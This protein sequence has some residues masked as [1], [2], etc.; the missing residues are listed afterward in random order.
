MAF[1]LRLFV[2]L[3]V[4]PFI[5]FRDGGKDATHGLGIAFGVFALGGSA[6]DIVGGSLSEHHRGVACLVSGSLDT[7]ALL[8]LTLFGW[9]ETAPSFLEGG[10][11]R[12]QGRR[13]GRRWPWAG[14]NQQQQEGE[15]GAWGREG[16]AAV[17]N[18]GAGAAGNA[19]ASCDDD[20]NREGAGSHYRVGVGGGGRVDCS[21]SSSSSA[22]SNNDSITGDVIVVADDGSCVGDDG[23]AHREC[24]SSS[25]TNL[26]RKGKAKQLFNPLSVL[27]VFLESRYE[28]V[29]CGVG[30]L[31]AVRACVRTCLHY[32]G[33]EAAPFPKNDTTLR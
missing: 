20:A 12:G 24:S 7:A 18:N 19:A 1:L 29:S 9:D 17:W 31:S 32:F 23:R 4:T 5:F 22:S 13:Q 30:L 26:T 11:G 3:V 25:S 21:S 33:L 10:R 28:Y 16:Q 15:E 27:K 14:E 6:G 8:S 2:L